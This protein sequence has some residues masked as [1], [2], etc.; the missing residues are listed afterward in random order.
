M[1]SG[2]YRRR[3]LGYTSLLQNSTYVS[4][5]MICIFCKFPP[6]ILCNQALLM[7]LSSACF[8]TWIAIP[9]LYMI[10]S[11]VYSVI[12]VDHPKPKPKP[13]GFVPWPVLDCHKLFL[14][15]T[16][17]ALC[18]SLRQPAHVSSLLESTALRT[19]VPCSAL[20][21]FSSFASRAYATGRSPQQEVRKVLCI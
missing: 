17:K 18:S 14:I 2:G 12:V 3:L 6:Q 16:G 10:S 7:Q 19:D 8:R 20:L 11:P 1:A 15:D 4:G 21:P 13:N 5:G 9:C